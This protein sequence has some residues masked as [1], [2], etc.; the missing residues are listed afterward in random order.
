MNS[1][2]V[3]GR[4]LQ[5]GEVRRHHGGS[6]VTGLRRWWYNGGT[7]MIVG[8]GTRPRS[9]AAAAAAHYFNVVFSGIR[10]PPGDIDT[11]ALSLA[12]HKLLLLLVLLLLFLVQQASAG[13]PVF[14]TRMDYHMALV[15][16]AALQQ[17]GLA[18]G[19]SSNCGCS[20]GAAAAAAA[21]VAGGCSGGVDRDA[22]TGQPT[23]LLRWAHSTAVGYHL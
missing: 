7:M 20:C 1:A 3:W 15:N 22:A 5:M 18:D 21:G 16:S 6:K 12:P 9:A 4:A 14:L 2:S 10:W 8:G 17:A 11:H 23:G 13:H 19:S